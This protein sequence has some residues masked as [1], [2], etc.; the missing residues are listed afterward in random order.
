MRRACPITRN[1]RPAITVRVAVDAKTHPILHRY[2]SALPDRRRAEALRLL[3]ELA[4]RRESESAGSQNRAAVTLPAPDSEPAIA[5]TFSAGV[6]ML[7]GS[8]D[9]TR[10]DHSVA[11]EGDE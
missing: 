2:L 11:D 4:L 10:L 1:M 3:G 9:A 7:L 6:G 8:L 5:A